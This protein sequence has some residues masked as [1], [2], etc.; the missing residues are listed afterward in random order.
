MMNEQLHPDVKIKKPHHWPYS[1]PI[2][3]KEIHQH[4]NLFFR[5][6]VNKF[7]T[8]LLREYFTLKINSRSYLCHVTSNK[9]N[10]RR[11]N[12]LVAESNNKIDKNNN[13]VSQPPPPA[14][15]AKH[16]IHCIGRQ[17]QNTTEQ[18]TEIQVVI[19]HQILYFSF[20]SWFDCFS[21]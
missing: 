7:S 9:L 16:C 17:Q 18:N 2:S 3:T 8:S 6:K 10:N 5:A 1:Q 11:K 4:C 13:I 14:T 20:R 15:T 12:G 21:G 19:P